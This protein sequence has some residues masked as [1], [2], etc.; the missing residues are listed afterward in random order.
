MELIPVGLDHDDRLIDLRPAIIQLGNVWPI[1]S[2]IVPELEVETSGL[3]DVDGALPEAIF[4]S[5][6]GD[7]VHASVSMG[8]PTRAIPEILAYLLIPIEKELLIEWWG[9]LASRVKLSNCLS[10]LVHPIHQEEGVLDLQ[11][12]ALGELLNPTSVH[13][14]GMLKKELLVVGVLLH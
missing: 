5:E 10:L 2:K 4:I 14:L 3:L 13:V 7:H 1:L 6:L 8:I 9:E 11:R 12:G